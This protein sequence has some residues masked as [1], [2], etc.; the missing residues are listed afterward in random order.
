VLLAQALAKRSQHANATYLNIVGQNMLCAFGHRVAMCCEMLGVVGSNLKLVKFEPTTPNTSQHIATRWPNA[1]NMFC[2]TM[3]GYVALACCDRLAGA[4]RLNNTQHV[5]TCRNTVA[6]R[7]QRV[8]PNNVAM[9]ST[10]MLQSFG[11]GLR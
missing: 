2:P 3:L 1:H 6:K 5:A 9:R 8:V 11:L 7:T 10:D 4:S